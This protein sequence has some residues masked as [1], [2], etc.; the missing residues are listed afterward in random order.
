MPSTRRLLVLSALLALG[1]ALVAVPSGAQTASSI[2]WLG[3]GED[4]VLSANGVTVLFG[5]DAPQQ[6]DSSVERLWAHHRADG[7]FQQVDVLPDGSQPPLGLRA[8]DVSDDG[9]VVA[10]DHTEENLDG[11]ERTRGNSTYVRTLSAGETEFICV[12]ESGEDIPL[13][14]DLDSGDFEHVSV[15]NDGDFAEASAEGGIA[16]RDGRYITFTSTALDLEFRFDI[17]IQDQEEHLYQR[18]RQL[19]ITRMVTVFNDFWGREQ[20]DGTNTSFTNPGPD[21]RDYDRSGDGRYIVFTSGRPWAEDDSGFGVDVYVKDMVTGEFRALTR[22]PDGTI[23]NGQASDV[24]ISANGRFVTFAADG[25]LDGNAGQGQSDD[26]G[27]R[28][29]LGTNT[30]ERFSITPDGVVAD[31]NANVFVSEPHVS[32]DGTVSFDT[33]ATNLVP[34]GAGVLVA[35]AAPVAP[36]DPTDPP[37]PPPDPEPDGPTRAEID[38]A[39]AGAIEFSQVRFVGEGQGGFAGIAPTH[40]DEADYVVLATVENFADALSGAV[41]AQQGPLL[42]TRTAAL[43]TNTFNEIIRL[44]GARQGPTAPATGTVY[45]L[46]GEAALSAD[47]ETTLAGEGYTIVRL[48]GASRFETSTAIASQAIELFGNTGE[49]A[50][51]RAFGPEGNPTAAWAD[52]VSGGA[53]SADS[54]TPTILTPSDSVHPATQTFLDTFSPGTVNLLGGSAALDESFDTI[55]GATRTAGLTR[56]DT[57]RQIALR[58]WGQAEEGQRTYLLL[59]VTAELGWTYGLAGAGISADLDGPTLGVAGDVA[60]QETLDAVSGC[61]MQVRLFRI[62]PLGQGILEAAD[63]ED[64][65]AC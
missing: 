41:L 62:G 6:A 52:S 61:G 12:N 64:A 21:I 57:A 59:D 27:W 33:N 60:P 25:N 42:F 43:D 39:I 35:N 26:A 7:T 31:A 44:L 9:D 16:S 10:F 65:A 19:G 45:L 24:H 36:V 4:T 22:L 48:A 29:D 15:S 54:G 17:P 13:N 58:L 46:G 37:P 8:Y 2:T 55:P 30:V 23:A 40:P 49:V 50:L 38:A 18:D 3:D 63:A 28:Y 1:A 14:C 32:D 11:V 20:V 5:A 34:D 53:W 51:A 56:F 47:V